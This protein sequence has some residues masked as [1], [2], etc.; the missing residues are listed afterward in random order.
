MI[1]HGLISGALFLCIG[2]MYDRLHTRDISAYGCVINVMPKFGAFMVLFALANSGL[3]GT[4]GFIGEFHA[5]GLRY[6]PD[7]RVV[8]LD[9]DGNVAAV[10]TTGPDGRYA[11]ENLAESDYTVIASGYP[12]AASTL[13]VTSGQP[14]SHDVHLGY[15]EAA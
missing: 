1:S 10:T 14:H 11:F 12:P 6:V 15:P 7:A 13:R 9:P 2:V 8:L 4:S 5:Q 3:P